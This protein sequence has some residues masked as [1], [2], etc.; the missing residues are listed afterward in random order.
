MFEVEL[1]FPVADEVSLRRTLASWSV[2]EPRTFTETDRYFNAPDR[3]FA[4]TDEALRIRLSEGRILLTYKGPKLDPYSKTRR[5]IELELQAAPETYAR[6]DT[7]LQALGFRPVAEVRK[8]RTVYEGQSSE[9]HI[10]RAA[11]DLVEGLGVYLE[12]ETHT[13][14]EEDIAALRQTMLELSR[15]WGLGPSERR[16]YLELLL[17]RRGESGASALRVV[18][19]VAELRAIVQAARRQGRRIGLVPTMGALHEGHASLIRAARRECDLV[20]VSVFVNPA[21]FGPREDYARYP[22]PFAEDCRLCQKWG[23]DVVFAPS[24]EAMYPP[25]YATWVEVHGLQ[26]VLCGRFRPGHFRGV[27]TVVL[28]LFNIAQPDLAYFG[29]KDAQQARIIEQ[30]VRDLDVPVELRICPTVREPDG[31]ALSSRNAYLS[32]SER[33]QATC[34]YRALKKAEELVRGG[35]RQ[36]ARLRQAMH[37]ILATV[38]Q[39]QVEYAEIVDARTLQPIETLDRRALAALAVRIGSA[40]LIDNMILEPPNAAPV[41]ERAGGAS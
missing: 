9:G 28:K 27:A 17:Q 38:P 13:E 23:V 29:Q 25:D 30:M 5:E 34:L 10:M 40:R 33:Q 14:R 16:S 7:F 31:L 20:V 21:Q 4:E 24:V 11:L 2:S 35:E 26:D 15:R 39:A 12:M 32:P 18:S 6:A 8:T 19:T 3:D 36:V 37:E 1:K 22:R 41:P